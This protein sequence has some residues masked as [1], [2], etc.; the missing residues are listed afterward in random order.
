TLA[1]SIPSTARVSPPSTPTWRNASHT[2]W[3]LRGLS[4][5]TAT[6]MT[7]AGSPARTARTTSL[8]SSRTAAF[9][10]SLGGISKLVSV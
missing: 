2:L 10:T 3:P 6:S 8:S 9:R 4:R 5:L 7:L 1:S